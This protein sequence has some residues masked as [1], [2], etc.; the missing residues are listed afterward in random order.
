MREAESGRI[1]TLDALRG[2]ALFG[3]LFVNLFSF[4]ADSIAWSSVSD[5]S[6]W[7]VKHILFESKFWGLYSILFG[8][9]FYLF[10]RS[11]RFSY[12]ALGRRLII[13]FL[14]G[15]IHALVFEGD[16][17]MLY[18]E[19]AVLLLLLHGISTRWLFVLVIALCM[20]FPLGHFIQP[21][22]DADSLPESV[23]EAERWLIED[24]ADDVRVYG[25]PS[26]I[27]LAHTDFI[28]EV[29]WADFQY[30]DSGLVVLA[31][32]LI[33]YLMARSDV[34]QSGRYPAHLKGRLLIGCWL[35]GLLLMALEQA[36]LR[37]L[38][39]SAFSESLSTREVTL[40]GDI[41]Y[42]LATLLL[43]A[44]WFLTVQ[45]CA[46]HGRFPSVINTL[47]RAGRMSLTLYLSQTLIFTTI[48]YGYGFDQAYRLGPSQVFL[49]AVSIYA[50]Q[51]VF[52]SLWLR[53]FCT[54]PLEWIWRMG[55]HGQREAIRR[56]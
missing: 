12:R 10:M 3:I 4:G 15:A 36:V 17:L 22:R 29:F 37:P 18:A 35:L 41:I 25:T 1:V 6:V 24:R 7:L 51:L 8:I 48:F 32:F 43:T 28:P 23:V 31:F 13:L 30:P 53:W 55:T 2:I 54:G 47:A 49:L 19:L 44:A 45:H 16:I 40:L 38:G 46:E 52:A 26:E 20:S 11:A 56:Q 9:S 34:L 39:Y 50:V 14:F 27:L 21:D 5:R 42:L 33:G